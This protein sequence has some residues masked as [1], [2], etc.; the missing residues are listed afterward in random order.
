MIEREAQPCS[1]RPEKDFSA[2]LMIQCFQNYFSIWTEFSEFFLQSRN[3]FY[4]FCFW[5]RDFPLWGRFINGH[6]VFPFTGLSIH[7][8]FQKQ[9]SII[10][11]SDIRPIY[12]SSQ[13]HWMSIFLTN[14]I[15]VRHSTRKHLKHTHSKD[16]TTIKQNDIL[17][18]WRRIWITRG[19]SA[20]YHHLQFSRW[21]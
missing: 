18:L 8:V 15:S 17:R 1:T 11:W 12:K 19:S 20:C 2:V 9:K 16:R 4:A 13:I 10:Q 3:D 14:S 5:C 7:P 6:Q 21:G